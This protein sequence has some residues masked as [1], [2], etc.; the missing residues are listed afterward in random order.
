MTPS[1]IEPATYWLVAP[2]SAPP[3]DPPLVTQSPLKF[4]QKL[5]KLKLIS[6]LN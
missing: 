6:M 4:Q 3:Y 5:T 2:P 1:G